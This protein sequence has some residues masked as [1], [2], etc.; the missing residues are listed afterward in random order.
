VD[1]IFTADP[2]KVLTARVIPFISPS[3]AAE[4]T[5]YGSEV[6]NPHTMAQVINAKI[7]IRIKNVMNPSGQGTYILP[8]SVNAIPSSKMTKF[9]LGEPLT[10]DSRSEV[11]KMPTAVTI[12]RPV[13][14]LNLCS[15]RKTRAHGFL[16]KVFQILDR[17]FLLVDLIAS[18]EVHISLALHSEHTMV[19]GPDDELGGEDLT[20]DDKR[21]KKA[22]DE[23][24]E[25]GSVDIV[26]GMTIISLVGKGLKRMTGI[27]GRFFG[28]LGE[29]GVNIE[30][31]SQGDYSL[32]IED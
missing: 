30:M 19:S 24:G 8:D 4:L 16:A 26:A 7:P 22:Y 13:I 3:E 11:P 23:L 6:I 17:N 5:F 32:S 10:V 29:A 15:N 9:L 12:K 18:S 21:L 27:A 28:V 20:I 2:R 31:I 14:V 1:G 25:L